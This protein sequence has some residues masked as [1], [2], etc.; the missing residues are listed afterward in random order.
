MSYWEGLAITAGINV[1]MVLGVT[2]LLGFTGLFT[3]GHAGFVAIGAYV[4]ALASLKLGTPLPVSL[5]LGVLATVLCTLPIGFPT[6]RLKGEYFV[7][8]SLGVGEI[9]GRLIENFDSIT[10]GARG[11][12]GIPVK[13]DLWVTLAF[14]ALCVWLVSNFRRSKYGRNCE[15]IRDNEMAASWIGIN[16][17]KY[18][19]IA[20]IISGALGGLGGGLL[21]HYVGLLSPSMFGIARSTDMT[22]MVIFGGLGSI[23]GSVVATIILSILPEF[24]RFAAEWRLVFYGVAVIA[25]MIVRPSGLFG[26]KELSF[27]FLK[28]LT[29]R[30]ITGVRNSGNGESSDGQ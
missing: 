21:A 27:D 8:A 20:L 23:T 14:V 19:M 17:F 13:T 1:I 24:L 12:P 4:S 6:L 29:R 28:R 25:L 5:L 30:P 18:K 16:P 9:I 3:F 10:G 7:V 26:N 11:L 15:A 2:V 22:I